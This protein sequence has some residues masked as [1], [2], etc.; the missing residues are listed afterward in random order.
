MKMF[1]TFLFLR[2]GANIVQYCMA[3]HAVVSGE[4]SSFVTSGLASR[5]Y[6]KAFK[7][8]R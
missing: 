7:K 3:C 6:I 5:D 2:R 8:L 1:F 4:A